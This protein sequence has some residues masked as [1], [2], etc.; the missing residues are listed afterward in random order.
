MITQH[1]ALLK[2]SEKKSPDSI[3]PE[4]GILVFVL[5]NG[6]NLRNLPYLPKDSDSFVGVLIISRR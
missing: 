6:N 5:G 4:S 3:K 2:K 1:F